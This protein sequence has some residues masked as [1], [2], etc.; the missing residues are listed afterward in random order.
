M[1]LTEKDLQEW[2]KS[3]FVLFSTEY[4]NIILDY[5]GNEPEPYQWS[6]QDI[7]EQINKISRN[8]PL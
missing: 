1:I 3:S 6:E 7:A 2:E 5:F 4:R 8:H